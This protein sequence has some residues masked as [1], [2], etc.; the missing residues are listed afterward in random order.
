MVFDWTVSRLF[1]VLVTL[2]AIVCLFGASGCADMP[3]G[4]RQKDIRDIEIQC[5]VLISWHGHAQADH[6]VS[7]LRECVKGAKR[8]LYENERQYV[9]EAFR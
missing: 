1:W 9:E 7:T 5:A 3:R 8:I 2:A 6:G 4:N